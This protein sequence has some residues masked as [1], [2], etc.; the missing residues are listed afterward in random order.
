[1]KYVL[2]ADPGLNGCLCLY[3]PDPLDIVLFDMPVHHITINNKKKTRIDVYELA[4]FIDSHAE[5]ISQAFVEAV[6]ASPQMGTTS[7]FAFGE[8]FGLLKGVIAANFISME[9]IRPQIWKKHFGLSQDKDAS[10]LKAS[11][12]FP[13]YASQWARAKDDGRSESLLIAVYGLS[14]TESVKCPSE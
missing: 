2:A 10:R 9:L 1:M 12:M 11:C 7:A 8:G 4:R 13:A 3:R 14:K 5:N 6:G